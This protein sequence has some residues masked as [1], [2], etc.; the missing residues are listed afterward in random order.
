MRSRI[1]G[2]TVFILLSLFRWQ[3]GSTEGLTGFDTA[4]LRQMIYDCEYYPDMGKYR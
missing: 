2:S 4:A 1:C 3:D